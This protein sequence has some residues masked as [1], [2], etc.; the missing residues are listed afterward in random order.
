MRIAKV[1]PY[2]KPGAVLL[3]IGSDDG[4][5]FRKIKHIKQ[6]IGIEPTLTKPLHG[7]NFTILPG[8]FPKACPPDMRFDS[9]TLLA[10]LEHI[11]VIAQR[12]FAAA[13]YQVLKPG[14]HIIITVPSARVD[15]IL[16]VLIKLHLVDGMSLEEHYG[17]DIVD[18]PEIFA[19]PKFRLVAHKT[20][21]FGLN[22]LFVFEK[23]SV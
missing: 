6:G 12:D 17:F 4:I 3:D 22:N 11:P 8:S 13:C 14:G 7:A 10:V 1:R 20:F 5:L 15:S 19:T 9:I 18:T 2:I 21:Q 16:K 23:R